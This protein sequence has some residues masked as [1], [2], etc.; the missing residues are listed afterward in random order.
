MRLT[1]HPRIV[2]Y[3]VVA[4]G[5]LVAAIVFKDAPLAA[6]GLPMLVAAAAGLALDSGVPTQHLEAE[7]TSEDGIVRVGNAVTV[8]VVL[9][10][11][12]PVAR[13]CVALALPAGVSSSVEPRWLVRLD[14]A[15]PLELE[16]EITP[17]APGELV[18]GPVS[19][20]VSGAGGLL[21]RSFTSTTLALSVRPR[22]EPVRS[23]P[24]SSRVRVPAGDRLAR[25][26][27]DGIELAEVRPEL[28]G[29]HYRRINWRA[30]AR[31]G[32]THVTLRH[33]EQ[34]TDVVL[35]VDTFSHRQMTRVLEV[36]SAA[37]AAYLAHRDRVGLV[38][39][40]GVLDWIEAGAGPRQ[41][42]R[43]RSRLAAT[44]PFFSYAWKTIDRIPVRAMPNG[45]LVVA[46]T[47]LG[48]E[49]FMS[50]LA[51]IRARG[52]EVVV[53]ELAEADRP[54]LPTDSPA[55]E[56]AV[57]LTGM[58]REDQRHRLFVRGMPVA[59]L[60]PGQP[61][62]TALHA[63]RDVSRKIRTAGRR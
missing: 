12:R 50:A 35:F 26:R 36:T 57:R 52:H 22:E 39:F 40:G 48:D 2:G 14:A 10:A 42:E 8:K 20:L 9:A 1:L 30:T 54:V 15:T 28:P 5:A 7:I 32:V 17:S 45:A 33:P 63:L 29:E 62:E 61:L 53:V 37:A 59:T 41:L 46:V 13:C 18:L 56:V 6:L 49:R 60:R 11:E 34:S 58:E 4:G 47:P 19:A 51:A 24:R 55:V 16:L 23:L 21:E 38:C 25:L 27:G 43:I 31:R 3:V 44:S